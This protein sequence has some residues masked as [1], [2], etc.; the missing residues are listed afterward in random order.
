VKKTKTWDY[1]NPGFKPGLR[2][3]CIVYRC[4]M[5]NNALDCLHN[6]RIKDAYAMVKHKQAKYSTCTRESTA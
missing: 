3:L 1:L 6:H 4:N 5:K 2:V